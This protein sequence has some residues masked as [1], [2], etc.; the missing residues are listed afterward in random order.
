MA[1]ESESCFMFVHSPSRRYTQRGDEVWDER[2]GGGGGSC[3]GEDA[4]AMITTDSKC[5]LLGVTW[6]NS[7]AESVTR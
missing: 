5:S 4:N 6:V 3:I 2:G 7:A 1:K